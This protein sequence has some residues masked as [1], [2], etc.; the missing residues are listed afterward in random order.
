[1][2]FLMGAAVNTLLACS[3]RYLFKTAQSPKDFKFGKASFHNFSRCG[4]TYHLE[5][6]GCTC[7]RWYCDSA[8]IY[9]LFLAPQIVVQEVLPPL[10]GFFRTTTQNRQTFLDIIKENFKTLIVNRKQLQNAALDWPHDMLS[11]SFDKPCL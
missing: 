9:Q 10:W 11:K 4:C 7:P 5:Q 6:G 1:M 3:Y 8:N 2:Y